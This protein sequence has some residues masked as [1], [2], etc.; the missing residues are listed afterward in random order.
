VGAEA[1]SGGSVTLV[2]DV[3]LAALH[4]KASSIRVRFRGPVHDEFVDVETPLSR[5]AFV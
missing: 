5:T 3:W 2:G 1:E 4:R